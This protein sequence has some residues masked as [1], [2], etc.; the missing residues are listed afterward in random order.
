[1]YF[2]PGLNVPGITEIE[3]TDF[4]KLLLIP[5]NGIGA[6]RLGTSPI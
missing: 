4:I 2:N 6:K 5:K 1:L 3:L